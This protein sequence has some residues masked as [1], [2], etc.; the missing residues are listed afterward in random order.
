MIRTLATLSLIVALTA[1]VEAQ[2]VNRKVMDLRVEYGLNELQSKLQLRNLFTTEA[3][4]QAKYPSAWADWQARGRTAAQFMVLSAADA[5]IADAV[6]R[7]NG[8]VGALGQWPDSKNTLLFPQG[9]YALTVESR[10][11]EGDWIGMGSGWTDVNNNGINTRLIP[12]HEQWQGSSTERVLVMVGPWGKA[13]AYQ[14]GGGL[15][16]MSIDGAPE[17]NPNGVRVIGV[18]A[19]ASTETQFYDDLMITRCHV[20]M[21]VFN[22]TPTRIGLLSVSGNI[23]CGLRSIGGWGGTLQIDILSGDDNGKLFE[24]VAGYNTV[25]GGAVSIDVIKNENGGRS[26]STFGPHRANTIDLSGSSRFVVQNLWFH[27][28]AGIKADGMIVVRPSKGLPLVVNIGAY[29]MSGGTANLFH[30]VKSETHAGKAWSNTNKTTGV[31][32][33]YDSQEGGGTVKING[34]TQ[35]STARN[36]TDQLGW[37]VNSTAF[38]DPATCTP[39]YTYVGYG[40]APPP[41]CSWVL[42]TPG[43]WGTCTNGMRSR[44][45]PYISSV[46]NCTPT[47]PKPPD[48]PETET[49]TTPCTSWTYTVATTCT[50]G[51]WA[52]RTATGVPAGCTGA[53]PADSTARTCPTVPPPTGSAIDVNDVLVV[54]NSADPTSSAMATAYVFQWGIP[55]GN[56]LTVNLGSADNLTSA[57]TLGTARGLIEARGKQY[58]VLA[59]RSPSRYNTS[60]SITSAIT[61]NAHNVSSLIPSA[62]YNYTGVKPRTDKGWAP[63]YLLIDAKYIRKDAHATKPAG[64]AILLL[65]KDAPSQGNPRGSTRATQSTTGITVWDSRSIS[66]VGGGE[67][68]CNNIHNDCWLTARKPMPAITAYYGSMYKLNSDAAVVWR[69]GYYGDHVTSCGGLLTTSADYVNSCGQTALTWHLDRGASMSVGSVVE[70]WQGSNGSLVQQF[71]NVTIFHPLFMGGKPVGVATYAAVQCPDRML[72][73]G[74]PLC[75]PYK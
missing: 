4:A 67:N 30:Q 32:M 20:G 65:A 26:T 35:T 21:E 47:T 66:G 58:T 34:N 50:N 5:A 27:T 28:G 14:V 49:C 61:F 41:T 9:T 16:S 23:E 56:V 1:P 68:V 71:V 18:R 24:Q 57:A 72:F 45:T 64:A 6:W 51:Q 43:N 19:W 12:F 36:C 29:G 42:G 44:T 7:G 63:S 40:A 37:T 39:A 8:G 70:P 69:K 60:Q 33:T 3:A 15:Q 25:A 46:Q 38:P 13:S 53:A 62:L 17:T 48:L 52:T 55:S 59:M 22:P 2:V 54:I 74:D 75:A 10:A 11:S 73:A 31:H